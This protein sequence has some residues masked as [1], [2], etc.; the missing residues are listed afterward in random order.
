MNLLSLGDYRPEVCCVNTTDKGNHLDERTNPDQIGFFSHHG[1]GGESRHLSLSRMGLSLIPLQSRSKIPLNGFGWKPYQNS[2]TTPEQVDR[3]TEEYP[4]CNWAV[5]LGQP[6]GVI[7]VDVDS[8]Q[9]FRWC[10]LQGGFNQAPPI[11]FETGRGWQYL[12]HLPAD[13]IDARG[14]NPHEGVEI[15]SNGQYSVIPPSIHPSGKPYTWKKPPQ[16]FDAIPYAPQWVLDALTGQLNAIPLD[17]P[18]TLNDPAPKPVTGPVEL[19]GRNSSLLTMRGTRWLEDSTFPKGCRNQALFCLTLLLKGAGLSK[20][21][22][23]ERIEQWRT[24][25]TRPIYGTFPDRS[26]E[27]R[28]ALEKAWRTPYHLQRDRLT[29]LRN[30]AGESMPESWAIELTRAYPS[31]KARSERVHKPL[32]ITVAKILDALKRANAFEPTAITHA[33]LARLAQVS[34]D[35]VAK[36]A[37]FL[38]EIGIR[39][40]TRRARSSISLY[41]LNRLKPPPSV[42][43]K[44][45]A[46][47][48]GYKWE[49][50]VIAKQLWRKIRQW[51]VKAF[52]VLNLIWNRIE[53][54]SQGEMTGGASGERGL[55][56]TRD[57]PTDSGRLDALTGDLRGDLAPC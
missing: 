52:N 45:F 50:K 35:Q 38:T 54:T 41:H 3:W 28:D 4:S 48:R 44:H 21:E 39:S 6:S 1:Y 12:F 57:P 2:G 17:R 19:A 55:T 33:E 9:A 15:R 5:L 11:W 31:L 13:L 40:T 7:A 30:V 47:W 23:I 27:P 49:W 22:A 46:R 34:P 29:A 14:V 26:R 10:E 18:T 36:V 8:T 42:L 56:R 53:S 51:V 43:I 32:F 20:R 16:S 24:A 25:R 37:G